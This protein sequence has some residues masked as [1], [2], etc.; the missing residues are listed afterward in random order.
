MTHL[1]HIARISRPEFRLTTSQGEEII[2][3]DV[4][5]AIDENSCFKLILRTIFFKQQQQRRLLFRFFLLSS[6]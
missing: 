1:T 6:L 3:P 5:T 2:I 4:R